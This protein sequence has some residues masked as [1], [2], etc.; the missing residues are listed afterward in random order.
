MLN[1]FSEG[2]NFNLGSMFNDSLSNRY[3]D[4]LIDYDYHHF[5][6]EKT[7]RSYE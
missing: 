1:V 5:H 2:D 3:L 7:I 4:D 6:D